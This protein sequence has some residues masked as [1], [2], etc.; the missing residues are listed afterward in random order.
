GAPLTGDT[1]GHLH[2]GQPADAFLRVQVSDYGETPRRWRGTYIAF[3]VVATAA[4]ATALALHRATRAVAG[5]YLAEETVEELSEGY[6]GF[7]A[8]N[9]LSRPVRIDADLIDARSGEVM[10]HGARTGLAGWNW[11]HLF[12]M[13]GQ[14]RDSLLATSTHRSLEAVLDGASRHARRELRCATP[15]DPLSV[16]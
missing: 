10:W 3:E 1:L 4:V 2:A 13:S 6:A 8:L 12:R 11:G 9:R 5:A 15:P 14:V 16:H 7:W